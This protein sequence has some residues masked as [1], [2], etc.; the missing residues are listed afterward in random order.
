MEFIVE[1][2]GYFLVKEGGV[3]RAACHL[4]EDLTQPATHWLSW[5]HAPHA[6]LLD[7]VASFFPEGHAMIGR[8]TVFMAR[9]R[10][11]TDFSHARWVPHGEGG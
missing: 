8:N 3:I 10:E 5:K 11:S 2:D 4:P 1:N 6:F 9:D 7:K